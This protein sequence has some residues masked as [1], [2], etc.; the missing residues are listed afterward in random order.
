MVV[1]ITQ[2]K[3]MENVGDRKNLKQKRREQKHKQT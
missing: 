1:H 3:E 2:I